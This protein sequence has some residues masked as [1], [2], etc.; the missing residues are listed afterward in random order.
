MIGNI[1]SHDKHPL[2]MDCA[3]EDKATRQAALDSG[4]ISAVPLKKNRKSPWE[5]DKE[6]YKR[7]N[8]IEGYFRRLKCFHKVFTR[9][10][11]LDMMLYNKT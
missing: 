5:Y 2:L 11:K 1:V 9:Y 10:D 7:R 3:Y 4:F 8:E 6:L